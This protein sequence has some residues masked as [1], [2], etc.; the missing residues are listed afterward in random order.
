MRA[1]GVATLAAL[2]ALGPLGGRARAHPLSPALLQVEELAGNRFAVAWKISVFQPIG[3]TL[4]PVLPAECV[5]ETPPAETAGA[6][7]I[8]ARWTARCGPGGL[9]GRDLG[10]DGL[11]TGKTD[12]LVRVTLADGR[13][14][15]GVLRASEP[16]LVIPARPRRLDVVRSYAKLGIEH[17]LTGPDHLLFVLGLLMLV[18]SPGLLVRTI[19]AFTVGHSITLSLAALG[20][21]RLPSRPIEVGIAASVFVLAVELS[22]EEHPTPTLLRRAPWAMAG[23][24]GL[25]HGLG[26]AGALA[27]VGLPAGEIPTALFAFNLGIELGQLCFVGLVL[28]V[29]RGLARLTTP[30]L[31]MA[32]WIPVYAM[33]SLSALWCIERTLA[34]VAPAW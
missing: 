30:R 31:L 3:A 7:S 29:A 34:L 12:A 14:V 4:R 1:L 22:R 9:A 32:R 17:I 16:R 26:F 11:A 6:D 8:T 2:V 10:V 18:G 25:L 24:F 13:L 27:E 20:L 23:V 28:V 5:A 21:A 19:T 33:G 15:Q